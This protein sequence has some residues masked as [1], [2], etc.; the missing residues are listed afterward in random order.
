[1]TKMVALLLLGILLCPMGGYAAEKDRILRDGSRLVYITAGEFMMGSEEHDYTKPVHKVK[2]KAFYMGKYEVTNAQYKKFCDETKRKYPAPLVYD[3]NYFLEKSDYPVIHVSW[4]D[5]AAYA[6]WAGGRLPT[7][8]EWEYA[9][10]GGTTTY[11]YW[12]E[13]L[14]RDYL[15]YIGVGERDKWERTSPIGAFL[16]NPFGLYDMLGNAWEWVADWYGEDYYRSST[17]NNPKGP[18]KGKERVFRGGGWS[19]GNDG[20]GGDRDWK[21]SSHKSEWVGFRIAADAR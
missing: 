12:G 18:Q 20:T 21:P 3:P 5:A 1:M 8:A 4:N 11:Y 2:L 15:N 7:E 17:V 14:S 16:P 13:E 10:R 19:G 6:K 9:A